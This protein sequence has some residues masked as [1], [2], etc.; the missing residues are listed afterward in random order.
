[1]DR[2]APREGNLGKGR[3]RKPQTIPRRRRSST[4]TGKASS[5]R[6]DRGTGDNK[7]TSGKLGQDSYDLNGSKCQLLRYTDGLATSEAKRV[8]RPYRMSPTYNEDDTPWRR[9][10]RDA[11]GS[12]VITRVVNPILGLARQ[13]HRVPQPEGTA[14]VG[15]EDARNAPDARSQM[16]DCRPDR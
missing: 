16:L 13:R 8:P 7:G 9:K 11:L 15:G 2:L 1:M 3:I 10:Q 12:P 6:L 4:D 14:P 5:R